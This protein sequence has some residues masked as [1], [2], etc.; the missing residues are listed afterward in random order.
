MVAGLEQR[1]ALFMCHP[2]GEEQD[3]EA[4]SRTYAQSL[5]SVIS[6]TPRS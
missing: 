6:A 5:M 1:Q 4:G 2:G 3:V